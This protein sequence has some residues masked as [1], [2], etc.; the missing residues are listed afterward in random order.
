MDRT[1]SNR[2]RYY[3]GR[4]TSTLLWQDSWEEKNGKKSSSGDSQTSQ[5]YTIYKALSSKNAREQ[6]I[7]NTVFKLVFWEG[8]PHTNENKRPC[9][10]MAVSALEEN[11]VACTGLGCCGKCTSHISLARRP[12]ARRKNEDTGPANT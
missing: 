12:E 2:V 6:N 4:S 1:E 8:E 11:T 7:P 3:Q 5:A 10:K 9:T